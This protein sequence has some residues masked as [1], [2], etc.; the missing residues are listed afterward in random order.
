MVEVVVHSS[1]GVCHVPM[2][3]A[4]CWDNMMVAAMMFGEGGGER[5]PCSRRIPLHC[6]GGAMRRCVCCRLRDC[7]G[8]PG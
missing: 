7:N 2:E 1:D 4:L 5:L 6:I 3:N 8:G